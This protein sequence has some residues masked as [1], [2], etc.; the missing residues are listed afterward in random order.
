M[1][2]AIVFKIIYHNIV[3][4]YLIGR[5]GADYIDCNNIS[6]HLINSDLLFGY[7]LRR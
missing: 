5:L 1:E 6:I 4:N 7:A 2:A 3:L